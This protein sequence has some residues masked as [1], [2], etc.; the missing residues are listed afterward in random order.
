MDFGFHTILSCAVVERIPGSQGLRS[1]DL[2]S[3][4]ISFIKI[5]RKDIW[6][7][8]HLQAARCPMELVTEVL[9]DHNLINN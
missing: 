3:I 1:M 6:L 7:G 4:L 8:P 9:T 5:D 2:Y